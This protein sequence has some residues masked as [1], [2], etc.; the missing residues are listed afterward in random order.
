MDSDGQQ[1]HT[2]TFKGFT[3]DAGSSVKVHTGAG[4][5][6]M[7][8]LYWGRST[9]VWNNNGDLA[10]LRNA[11]GDVVAQYPKDKGT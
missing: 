3:L 10:I 5:D 9:P 7:T 8:D 4:N 2:Y 1:N 6:S 11:A